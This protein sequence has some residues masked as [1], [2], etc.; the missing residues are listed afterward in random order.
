MKIWNHYATVYWLLALFFCNCLVFACVPDRPLP[1]D[2]QK[3]SV[4]FDSAYH[5]VVNHMVTAYDDLDTLLLLCD[6]MASVSPSLL[7]TGQLPKW[8]H[9]F[10]LAASLYINDND[11]KKALVSL[12]RGMEVADS[13]G[14]IAVWNR[15]AN[16]LALVYSNWKLD[17]EANALFNRIMAYSEQMDTLSRANAYLAKAMHMAYTEKYDSA[18]YYM[19]Q[20]DRLQIKEEDML[21]GSYQSVRYFT[22]FLKGWYLAEMPDS[23]GRAIGLL[24]ELHDEYYPYRDQAISFESVCFRLGR[25]YDLAGDG[26]KARRYYNEAKG[27]IVSKPANYQLFEVADS[28]MDVYLDKGAKDKAVDL[29]PAYKV[30]SGQYH[31]FLMDGMLVY[32]SVKLDVAGK[33]KRI[34]QA[35]SLLLRRQMEVVI[36]ALVVILLVVLVIWGIVYWRNK[37]RQIHTLFE[38]LM[39]RYIEWREMNLYLLSVSNH[40]FLLS[41]SPNTDNPDG[42]EAEELLSDAAKGDD[43]YR[44]L[45]Y[46]VLLVME[47]ERP[48]LNPGLNI[49]LLAKAVATNRT[50]LSSAINRMTGSSFSAWLAEY[51]VNYVIQLMEIGGFGNMD[52]LYEQAGFGSKT[53]FYRQ[54]KQITGLTPKQF[55]KR[56]MI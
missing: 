38:A 55:V 47:K 40:V 36:L 53:S 34:M 3:V 30:I 19:S 23:L 46:R 6:E 21:S 42:E 18:S 39:R 13:L 41:V 24:Q 4:R 25:A 17:D 48:F 56:R 33:E 28:L 52:E 14:N 27:L 54:F 1:A 12:Q 37:K 32:Y 11:M 20:I 10:A 35:E 31:D 45:Y 26:K 29:L 2:V 22:R 44:E 5:F 49:S 43:F 7:E 51:R 50:Y 16:L 15:A 9:S 8:A